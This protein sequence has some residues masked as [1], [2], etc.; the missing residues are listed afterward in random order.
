LKQRVNLN[1]IDLHKKEVV[2]ILKTVEGSGDNNQT[3]HRPNKVRRPHNLN[4]TNENALNDQCTTSHPNDL[5]K[6]FER[7]SDKVSVKSTLN[8]NDNGILDNFNLSE[9]NFNLYSVY[10]ENNQERLKIKQQIK[11]KLAKMR[12]KSE[13]LTLLVSEGDDGEGNYSNNCDD[14][15]N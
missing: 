12:V 2:N 13:K 5:V 15:P 14:D 7:L 3:V 1:F 11:E 8:I 10:E 9:Y 4:T 6:G